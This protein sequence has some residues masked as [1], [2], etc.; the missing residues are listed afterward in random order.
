MLTRTRTTMTMTMKVVF[1]TRIIVSVF[2]TFL[3]SLLSNTVPGAVNG[4]LV[5]ASTI[6]CEQKLRFGSKCLNGKCSNPFIKGC[7]ST[8]IEEQER[9]AKASSGGNADAI[10]SLL[11]DK[12]QERLGLSLQSNNYIRICNSD[13]YKR[14]AAAAAAASADN[15]S[16]TSSFSARKLE[17]TT[18]VAAVDVPT[19]VNTDFN[20]NNPSHDDDDDDDADGVESTRKYEYFNG[21]TINSNDNDYDNLELDEEPDEIDDTD[22]TDDEFDDYFCIPNYLEYPEIRI[23][24]CKFPQ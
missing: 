21:T 12:I 23:H 15:P 10:A 2:F 18:V 16:S 13:D 1:T 24:D 5:C 6:E 3:L 11:K 20:D 8:M 22:E 14:R 19:W 7:L 9:G 17:H 4:E